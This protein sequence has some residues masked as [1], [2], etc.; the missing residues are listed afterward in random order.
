MTISDQDWRGPFERAERNVDH[1]ALERSKREQAQRATNERIAQLRS[2]LFDNGLGW[3]F[4]AYA[5]EPA[6]AQAL[7][8]AHQSFYDAQVLGIL[9]QAM[10][11]RWHTIVEAGIRHF[12]EA[13]T[14]TRL[15]E[16]WEYT[17]TTDRTSV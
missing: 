9:K 7:I 5:D 6:A 16:V 1:A 13:G 2:V 3:S 10:D 11:N 14:A 8:Q 12:G 4:R 15:R 17:R